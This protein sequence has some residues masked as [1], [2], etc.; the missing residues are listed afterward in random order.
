MGFDVSRERI[1]ALRT[2][3]SHIEDV[4]PELLEAI[5][6]YATQLRPNPHI[7]SL[8]SVTALAELRGKEIGVRYAEALGVL[9]TVI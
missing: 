4:S 8:E 5:R 1:D 9:R 3:R 6:L 7:R 2:G